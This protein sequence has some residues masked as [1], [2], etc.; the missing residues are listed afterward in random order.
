MQD[1]VELQPP[2]LRNVEN[3]MRT[4]TTILACIVLCGC[5]GTPAAT[6]QDQYLTPLDIA[7]LLPSA[8]IVDASYRVG[9]GD[10]LELR[11]FQVEDLSFEEIFVDS[12]GRLQLP[13]IGSIAAAGM[14][15]SELSADIARR[16]AAQ[17]LRDP[18]VA[19]S[20]LEAANNK[21]TVDG[22]VKKPGVFRLQ[23]RTTL[24]Q[25][26]SMAEGPTGVA[27]VRHVAVFRTVE[28]RRMVAAFDLDQIRRGAASD[29]EILGDD[30]VVVDTSR[31][32]TRLRD[33]IQALPALGF[34]AYL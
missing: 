21:V 25:A 20:V 2:H 18:Q 6:P 17:Y 12:S 27:N 28:G 23:G 16:F 32:A 9:P 4:A 26:V 7:A 31:L 10:K 15:P 34:F 14:T 33:V 8:S 1:T 24:L 22:A 13:L 19:V 30:I 3:H 29:P 11:V 5:A